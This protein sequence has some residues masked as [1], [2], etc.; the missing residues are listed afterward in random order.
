MPEKV[1]YNTLTEY[2]LLPAV[3]RRVMRPAEYKMLRRGLLQ[4]SVTSDLWCKLPEERPL[5]ARPLRQGDA[6]EAWAI[7]ERVC[8]DLP[9][10]G[11]VAAVGDHHGAATWQ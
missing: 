9:E 10:V 1:D 5:A 11:A 2:L 4:G 3:A 6:K 7:T 8:Q